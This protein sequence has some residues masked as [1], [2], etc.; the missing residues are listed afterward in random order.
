MHNMKIPII[1]QTAYILESLPIDKK[2]CNADVIQSDFSK[3][4]SL[5]A[6]GK[7]SRNPL[8]I[9]VRIVYNENSSKMKCLRELHINRKPAA[10]QSAGSTTLGKK[11]RA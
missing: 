4:L 1:M 5:A 7:R 3:I 8:V 10:Q 6:C 11:G 2:R 9:A